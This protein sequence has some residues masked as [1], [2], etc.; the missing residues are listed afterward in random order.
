MTQVEDFSPSV[1]PGASVDHLIVLRLGLL[2]LNILRKLITL[3]KLVLESKS[4]IFAPRYNQFFIEKPAKSRLFRKTEI[5]YLSDFFRIERNHI[6]RKI[7]SQHKFFFFFVLCSRS[8]S[9]FETLPSINNF[10]VILSRIMYNLEF[11]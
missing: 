11:I 10:A 9:L 2:L 5:F 3:T 7:L 8:L 6:Y 1:D 4:M